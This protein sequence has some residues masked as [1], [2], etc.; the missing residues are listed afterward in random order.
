MKTWPYT[1][2]VI[3]IA[4]G[5]F[6]TRAAWSTTKCSDYKCNTPEACNF[7][8]FLLEK[9]ATADVFGDAA[10]TSAYAK[11]FGGEHPPPGTGEAFAAEVQKALNDKAFPE[12]KCKQ[13]AD[14]SQGVALATGDNC[15]TTATVSTDN[16]DATTSMPGAP[17]KGPWNPDLDKINTCSEE[18]KASEDHEQYHR[19][20]CQARAG[21][22]RNFTTYVA[23]DAAAYQA[24]L[25]SAKAARDAGK[26]HCS[27]TKADVDAATKFLKDAVAAA[28]ASQT[29][30][31]AAAAADAAQAAAAA[32]AKA[33]ASKSASS[34]S[35]SAAT[36]PTAG[37]TDP[38][39]LAAQANWLAHPPAVN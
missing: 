16:V 19:T 5:A 32:A 12:P 3:A 11:S 30:A 4:T 28:T 36:G 24:E 18:L 13:K 22:G 1:A 9:Q 21:A 25:A 37:P 26:Y 7:K 31:T 27:P 17:A 15:A 33:A 38:A 6:A 14:V 35:S 39:T 2:A 20:Q 8:N 23:E 34:S 10:L 29:A